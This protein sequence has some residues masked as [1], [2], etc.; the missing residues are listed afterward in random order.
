MSG[1]KSWLLILNALFVLVALPSLCLGGALEHACFSCPQEDECGHEADCVDDPCGTLAT[2]R[3][4]ETS[5]APAV[6]IHLETDLHDLTG[7]D[8]DVGAAAPPSQPT[9]PTNLPYEPHERPLRN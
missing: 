1:M 9:G 8:P 6:P 3:S 7:S 4:V 5:H 2:V